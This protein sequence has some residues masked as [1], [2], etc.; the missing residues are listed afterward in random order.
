MQQ[1]IAATTEAVE[2]VVAAPAGAIWVVEPGGLDAWLQ[3]TE[4][5]TA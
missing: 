3:S 1:M 2:R 4:G 5:Q